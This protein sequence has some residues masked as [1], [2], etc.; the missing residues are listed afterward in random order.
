MATGIQ[1]ADH[2]NKVAQWAEKIS[3]CRSSGLSV[4]A[5]CSEHNINTQTYYRWQKRLFAMAA[6]QHEPQ[7]AEITQSYSHSFSDIAVTIRIHGAEADIHTGADTATI[8]TVLQFL[9][10]C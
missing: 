9:R 6:A 1:T 4:R 5:W 8:E 7:F 2:Q 3:A 10:S